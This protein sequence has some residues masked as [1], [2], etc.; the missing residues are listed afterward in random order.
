MTTFVPN[1]HVLKALELVLDRFKTFSMNAEGQQESNFSLLN[2]IYESVDRPDLMEQF[3]LK[4]T[5]QTGTFEGRHDAIMLMKERY[6]HRQLPDAERAELHEQLY[7][8]FYNL[9]LASLH[10]EIV[11]EHDTDE[12]NVSADMLVYGKAAWL[13]GLR[14]PFQG[15]HNVFPFSNIQS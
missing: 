3:S 5:K 8:L 4:M 12:N 13:T 2:E 9:C 1:K 7:D 6:V 11:K 14:L 10:H 15:R